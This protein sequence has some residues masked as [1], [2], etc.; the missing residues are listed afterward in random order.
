MGFWKRPEY[1]LWYLAQKLLLRISFN[2][3]NKAFLNTRALT[4]I[5]NREIIFNSLREKNDFK[6]QNMKR[7]AIVFFFSLE[8]E[9]Y[10]WGSVQAYSILLLVTSLCILFRNL[11][12]RHSIPSYRN[13]RSFKLKMLWSQKKKKLWIHRYFV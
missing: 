13:R 2:F 10:C 5:F 9:K 6:E 8:L 4:D 12:H 7:Y 11:N 3:G 1:M